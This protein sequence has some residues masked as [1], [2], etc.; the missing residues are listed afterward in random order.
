MDQV[1]S[2][3]Q[4]FIKNRESLSVNN[5]KVSIYHPP[6]ERITRICN[7]HSQKTTEYWKSDADSKVYRWSNDF[8]SDRN[9]KSYNVSRNSGM[10][11]LT[12]DYTVRAE[13]VHVDNCLSCSNYTEKREV[14]SRAYYSTQITSESHKQYDIALKNTNSKIKETGTLFLKELKHEELK[15]S[16][17]L[18]HVKSELEKGEKDF[19]NLEQAKI[20]KQALL[21]SY[22]RTQHQLKLEQEKIQIKEDI[23][24]SKIEKEKQKN[25]ELTE[26]INLFQTKQINQTSQSKKLAKLLLNQDQL[27]KELCIEISEVDLE[28]VK[29]IKKLSFIERAKLCLKSFEANDTKKDIINNYISY[30]GCDVDY[31]ALIAFESDSIK[32][33]DYAL[34]LGAKPENYMK[35]G[36]SLLQKI[37]ASGRATYIDY[38]L[39]G[40]SLEELGNTF[41]SALKIND[42]YTIN[43]LIS[44]I[45][46]LL[47]GNIMNVSVAEFA[48]YTKN[49]EV[50]NRILSLDPAM[51]SHKNLRGESL[52]HIALNHGT[53][54]SVIKLLTNGIIDI[55]IELKA[56][57]NNLD[58][59]LIQKLD[60]IISSVGIFSDINSKINEI[61]KL[62][63]KELHTDKTDLY[64]S[65]SYELL[66]EESLLIK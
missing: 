44:Y 37:I 24:I 55:E 7:S 50:L 57:I 61:H 2:S 65:I 45:P 60:K 54:E 28:I 36:V 63:L 20:D 41:I 8:R 46:D 17:Q 35:D 14:I 15:L 33:F 25:L 18:L 29:E 3:Y 62:C 47:L 22:L 59:N 11:G 34:K 32:A 27:Y 26:I 53:E 5:F 6:V 66:H 39:K 13:W 16:S 23:E 12:E 58:K 56:L 21:E 49:N 4:N 19:I 43:T 64:D 31:L 52:L 1:K 9:I 51:A 38:S 40:K 10:W 48:I 30:M 42:F